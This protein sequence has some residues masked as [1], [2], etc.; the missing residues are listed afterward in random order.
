MNSTLTLNR[1]PQQPKDFT[2]VD[3]AINDAV[4]TRMYKAL[5]VI[6]QDTNIVSFLTNLDPQALN[7]VI[8]AIEEYQSSYQEAD[9]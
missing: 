9:L 6:A 2:P 4:A 8:G 3:F 1:K 7:Q 5:S